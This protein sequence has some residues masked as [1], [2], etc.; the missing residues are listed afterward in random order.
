MKAIYWD[1][2]TEAL[3][4]ITISLFNEDYVF[5]LKK[6]IFCEKNILKRII[7]NWEYPELAWDKSIIEGM[8]TQDCPRDKIYLIKGKIGTNL[9]RNIEF[10]KEL[11]ESEEILEELEDLKELEELEEPEK[12]KEVKL[13]E[14]EG[15]LEELSERLKFKKKKKEKK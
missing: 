15:S 11:E 3:P 9:F 10:P 2:S 12:S 7:G 5:P 6:A 1:D 13:N 8:I 4:E 14:S